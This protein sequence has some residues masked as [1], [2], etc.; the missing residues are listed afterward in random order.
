[1]LNSTN[2]RALV[3]TQD[4]WLIMTFKAVSRDMGIAAETS[5]F[6]Q[7]LPHELERDRYEAVL[8][9]YDTVGDTISDLGSIRGSSSNKNIVVLAVATDA[10]RR[11]QALNDG[12]RFLLVRPFESKEIKQK[13]DTAYDLMKRE[14]RRYF[15]CAVEASVLVLRLGSGEQIRCR[16]I[17][18][19]SNGMALLSSMSFTLGEK[20]KI[21]LSLS[22]TTPAVV[23]YGTVVWDDK[24]GKTG[25]TA[26]CASPD[27]Q[28]QLDA[29]LD[30]RFRQPNTV[31]P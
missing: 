5:T 28:R 31:V 2:L 1:M 10:R 11:E 19:S 17:N 4:P 3:V 22:T 27:M 8:V 6:T 24:H 13:L 15:R 18:V 23:V 20:L 30:A 12:V 21:T 29:W 7:Q 9:D 25:I 16:T 26:Q 14:R